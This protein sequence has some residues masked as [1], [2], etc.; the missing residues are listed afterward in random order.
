MYGDQGWYH[1]TP[2]KYTRNALHLFF[3]TQKEDDRELVASDSWLQFLEGNNPSYP[4][5]ALRADLARIRA[6]VQGIRDDETTPDTRLS[7]DPMHLNPASVRSLISLTMGGIH[8]ERVGAILPCSVRYFDPQ[9][10]RAGLPRDVAALVTRVTSD[11]LVVQLVNTNQLQRRRIILQAGGYGEHRFVSV[12]R[13][14]ERRNVNARHLRV[15]LEPGAGDTLSF[16]MRRH[17]NQP[18]FTFP[19]GVLN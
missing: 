9:R 18:R 2:S 7:D 3:L 10:R 15:V 16:R 13:G 8:P 12:Q 1:Y 4:E 17:A 6:S 5:R 19:P 14:D 11:E